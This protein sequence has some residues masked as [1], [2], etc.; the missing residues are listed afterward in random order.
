MIDVDYAN[1]WN[2]LE[3]GAFR[4][5]LETELIRGFR[6]IHATGERLPTASHYASQ[7]SE[8]INRNAAEPLGAEVAYE[9]YQ[10]V[11]AACE[12]ARAAVL[13]EQPN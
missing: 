9:L 5:R 12:R 10:E 6:Q 4:D 3:T 2:E 11:L 8:I 13:G 1:L 7:I